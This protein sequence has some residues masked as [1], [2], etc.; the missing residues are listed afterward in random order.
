MRCDRI[1]IPMLALML[2]GCMGGASGTP[3]VLPTATPEPTDIIPTP[4]ST[5]RPPPTVTP[6]PTLS[7]AGESASQPEVTPPTVAEGTTASPEAPTATTAAPT[8]PPGSPTPTPT[9][10]LVPTRPPSATPTATVTSIAPAG[11]SLG[12]RLYQAD[13][14]QGWETVDERN[15]RIYLSDG[16]Y[17]FEVGPRDDGYIFTGA[18]TVDD[19][20]A[21]VEVTPRECSER[22]G[23]GLRFRFVD[24]SNYYAFNVW[25]DGTYTVT[26]REGGNLRTG[27]AGGSLPEALGEDTH[28]LAVT[29]RGEEFAVYFDNVLLDTFEDDTHPEGDIAIFAVSQSTG[30][31]SVAFDNLGVWS[32]R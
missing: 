10:T 31:V 14:Y 30:V 23:F 12:N 25:C 6:F 17:V 28:R 16:V 15:I 5:L 22:S 11:V 2:V 19:F 20:Y 18:L 21:S 3:T 8:Q 7:G 1:I 4:T 27:L 9:D 29:A 26:A 32:L 13:F 24:V